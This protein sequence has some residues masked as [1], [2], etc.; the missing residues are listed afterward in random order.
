M[1]NRT[2]KLSALSGGWLRTA[3]LARALVCDPDVLLLDEPTTWMWKLLNG[4]KI[5]YWISKVALYLFPMTVLLFAKW[6]HGL[7][8]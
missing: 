7:W 6:Q 1:Q 3:A 8:I 5:S 4:W 2:T